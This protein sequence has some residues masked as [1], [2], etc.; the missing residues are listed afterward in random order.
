MKIIR[1]EVLPSTINAWGFAGAI[2]KKKYVMENGDVWVEG[3]AMYRHMQP[4]NYIQAKFSEDGKEV[5]FNGG[6][7]ADIDGKRT[8]KAEKIIAKHY[9]L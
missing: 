5:N 7:D 3:K 8:G 1:T 9:E 6:L 4:S 2:N